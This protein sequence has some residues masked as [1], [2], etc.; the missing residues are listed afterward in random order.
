MILLVLL[1]ITPASSLASLMADIEGLLSSCASILPPGITQP[2]QKKLSIKYN[3]NVIV[4]DKL[5]F[6]KVKTLK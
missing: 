6:F 2:K 1:P 5:A 3:I 4:S